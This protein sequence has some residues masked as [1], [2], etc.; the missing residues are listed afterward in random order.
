MIEPTYKPG[1]ASR[2]RADMDTEKSDAERV[3]RFRV[4]M[5]PALDTE[6]KLFQRG[7]LT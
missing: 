3:Y 4:E 2:L 5:L 7:H 1:C 6:A